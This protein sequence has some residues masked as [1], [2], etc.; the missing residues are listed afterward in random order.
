[1]VEEKRTPSPWS[2]LKHPLF[3]ALWIA[4]AASNI[5]TWMQEVGQSW[6]MTSLTTSPLMV[7]L[8]QTAESLPIFL[9]ALG[10][11]AL[12]DVVD[13]RRLL[14][15]TQ[16]WMLVVSGGLGLVTLAGWVSPWLLLAFVFALGLG[17][18]LNLPAWQAVVP[19]LVSRDE[20][21]AAVT[22]NGVQ[23]N[24]ARAVGPAL[25]GFIVAA[26]GPAA[27]FLLNALSFLAVIGVL[28]FW[29]RVPQESLLPAERISSAMRA[30]LRYVRHAPPFQG[31]LIRTAVFILGAS[32][33]WAIL[34]QFARRELELDSL[35][36][37][38]MLGCLGAGAVWGA[39]L[40]P[41]LREHLSLDR[42][43]GLAALSFGGVTLILA[44]VRIFGVLCAALLVAGAAWMI[45]MSSFN[46]AAQ[47]TSPSWV[48]ARALGVYVLVFQG[49]MAGGSAA[50]GAVAEHLSIS[51]AF[52][53]AAIV[54]LIGLAVVPRY[55]LAPMA[56]L[57]LT[58]SS[59]WQNPVAVVPLEPDQGPVLITVEYRIDSARAREFAALM[60]QDI[61]L[62]RRRDGAFYWGLYHDIADPSRYLETFLVE[63]WVEHLRQHE[64]L[65][66]EDRK[67][68][69]IVRAFHVDPNPPIV[70]HFIAP[71]VLP[72]QDSGPPGDQVKLAGHD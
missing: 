32:A 72:S 24:V 9:L 65:T 6:L 17:A 14:L 11:G 13:R 49:G 1:M 53:G 56:D 22:L 63:S 10:A 61:R 66:A 42:M 67:L 8:V 64:R 16:A 27:S 18:A 58:P 57:D 38:I 59:H 70:T 21:A 34:P 69:E 40:M 5:G 23:F 31:V 12:A 33:L 62:S 54:L 47:I 60:M 55:R 37:G 15:V 45:V 44:Y 43:V 30:G 71:A 41:R 52:A 29:R 19:E 36:Y 39:F 48:R 51:I 4:A 7:A 26:A 20:L 25:G 50:W 68:Q 3:R 28:Y 35:G 46:V 2:P